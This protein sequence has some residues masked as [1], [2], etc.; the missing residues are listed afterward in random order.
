[1]EK[2]SFFVW[3]NSFLCLKETDLKYVLIFQNQI[4][5]KLSCMCVFVKKWQNS[6]LGQLFRQIWA[7]SARCRVVLE[8][9]NNCTLITKWTAPHL[10]VNF[11]NGH[12]TGCAA[13]MATK[14]HKQGKAPAYMSGRGSNRKPPAHWL[15]GP[16]VSKND[17][18]LAKLEPWT[19][20]SAYLGLISKV[21][22]SAGAWGQLHT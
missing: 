11:T 21:Q 16:N 9:E 12:S 14:N 6:N 4:H 22:S 2:M 20:V 3:S 7:S 1:M 13:T 17:Q 8:P 18:A 5:S 10:L 19:A 15:Q